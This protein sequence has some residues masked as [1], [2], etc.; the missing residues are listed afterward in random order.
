MYAEW[1]GVCAGC[2][3]CVLGV[4]MLGVCVWVTQ[5]A[6]SSSKQDQS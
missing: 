5:E 1:A 6:D 2:T 4:F 3:V